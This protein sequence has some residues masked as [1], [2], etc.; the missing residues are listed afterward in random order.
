MLASDGRR[1]V[2]TG[3]GGV[4]QA[5]SLM[6]EEDYR[7]HFLL[8]NLPVAMSVFHESGPPPSDSPPLSKCVVT[9]DGS[10]LKAYETGYPLGHVTRAGS[11]E[12]FDPDNDK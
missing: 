1:G 8:D 11:M 9:H 12:M 6:I 5:F 4:W 7:A 3:R 10:T 2:M